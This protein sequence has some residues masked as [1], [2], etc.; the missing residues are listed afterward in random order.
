[1]HVGAR[2]ATVTVTTPAAGLHMLANSLRA[3]IMIV[4]VVCAQATPCAAQGAS[5]GADHYEVTI[6]PPPRPGS[7]PA[8][9]KEASVPQGAPDAAGP[10]PAGGE[11][12][13]QPLA[14]ETKG[15]L[16]TLQVGAYRQR[17]SADAMSERLGD[18]FG[19]VQIVEVDSGGEK[20]YRVRV[21]RLPAG[22][23]LNELKSR[24]LAAG[25]PAFEVELGDAH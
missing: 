15:P 16:R 18:A 11:A 20:L 14:A 21:G 10:P 12:A 6:A 24:L 8:A 19:E 7:A 3:A 25:Y 4:L 13:Q 9:E 17:S 22:P 5:P 2:G 1:M 23:A